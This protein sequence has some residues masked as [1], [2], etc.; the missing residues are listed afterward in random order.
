MSARKI[1][2]LRA[3]AR[4]TSAEL[5]PFLLA[6]GPLGRLLQLGTDDGLDRLGGCLRKCLPRTLDP[7]IRED[8]VVDDDPTRIRLRL[9]AAHRTR[10][11]QQNTGTTPARSPTKHWH[12]AQRTLPS[13]PRVEFIGGHEEMA[14]CVVRQPKRFV[15]YARETSD[16]ETICIDRQDDPY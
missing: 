3:D 1:T 2:R 4:G 6:R 15:S 13:A 10:N 5:A 8:V 11:I 16:E 9:V 7:A 14:P 12:P